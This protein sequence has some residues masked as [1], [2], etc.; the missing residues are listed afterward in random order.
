MIV[1]T[2]VL[3]IAL[4]GA[5]L[6]VDVQFLRL[7]RL[8]RLARMVRLLRS[9]P[10]LFA[11]VKATGAAVRSVST[12]M[13]LLTLLLYVF[14]ILFRMMLGSIPGTM[15]ERFGSIPMAMTTLFF[16]GTLGDSVEG[17]FHE[18]WYVA[19]TETGIAYI[20]MG[21]FFLFVFLSMFTV[22]NMLIGILCEVVAAI[23]ASS[24]E[25][26]LVDTVRETLL[27]VLQQFDEDGNNCVSKDEFELLMKD[28]GAVDALAS[29]DIDVSQFTKLAAFL[30]EEDEDGQSAELPF[31]EFMKRCL[32]MRST[33]TARVL[34]LHQ[35]SKSISGE[36][37][38]LQRVVVTTLGGEAAD[39]AE[40]GHAKP[41]TP[42]R[43]SASKNSKNAP[44]DTLHR[45]SNGQ[46]AG[47]PNWQLD[48]IEGK[49]DR[50]LAAVRKPAPG[51]AS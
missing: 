31:K 10:E 24:R 33:N 39:Q 43:K 40:N 15:N 34:D 23:S 2:W 13:V 45:A 32:E 37:Q 16:R 14:A 29:L 9:L 12:V 18:I 27:S 44:A 35:M 17:V 49:L 38:E 6:P 28:P 11:L 48:R 30:F 25:E 19:R 42:T 5:K 20:F 47:D 8:L 7:L 3:P 51:A 1:E 36:I 26:V 4:G 46:V 41:V 22:L 21:A 50:V